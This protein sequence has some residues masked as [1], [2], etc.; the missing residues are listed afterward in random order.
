MSTVRD[1]HNLS[2]LNVYD[3]ILKAR[4]RSEKLRDNDAWFSSKDHVD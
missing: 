1:V 4:L 3:V 2:K